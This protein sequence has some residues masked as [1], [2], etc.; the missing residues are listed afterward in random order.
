MVRGDRV[1]EG[2]PMKTALLALIAGT[3]LSGVAAY[4]STGP[5]PVASVTRTR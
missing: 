1:R 4:A 3:I 2:S 5:K